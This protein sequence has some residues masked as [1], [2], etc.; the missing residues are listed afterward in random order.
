MMSRLQQQTAPRAAVRPSRKGRSAL[1][2][3]HIDELREAFSLFDTEKR[4]VIDARE[5]KAAMRALGFEV[6]KEQV[7]RM[8]AEIGRDPGASIAFDDFQ[9]LLS[10][11]MQ[12]KGSREDVMKIFR[13]FDED[14]LGKI[15][16]KALKRVAQ[17]LGENLSD[18]EMAEMIEEADRDGDGALSFDEF[19]RVMSRKNLSDDE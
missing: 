18:A 6:T 15:T 17:E 1:T 4:G 13:L 16:F 19:Y 12:T 9:D 3:E 5:L 10:S 7:R 11:R 8:L 14:N 2:E